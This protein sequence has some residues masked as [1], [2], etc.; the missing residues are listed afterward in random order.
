LIEPFR[1]GTIMEVSDLLRV[2]A[3]RK[4]KIKPA[5]FRLR[6]GEKGLSLFALIEQPGLDDV[7]RAVRAAGK[8]G[9]LVA[10]VFAVRDLRAMGLRIVATKGGTQVA[11]V[12]AIHFEARIPWWRSLFLRIRG[13]SVDQYFNEQHSARLA[14]RAKLLEGDDR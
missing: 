6:P 9:D 12:N 4:G 7:I 11:E 8:Q 13:R 10:A 2:V 3:L 5:E 1:D 14:E